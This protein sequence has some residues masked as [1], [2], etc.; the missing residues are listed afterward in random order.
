MIGGKLALT[1]RKIAQEVH[2]QE[3]HDDAMRSMLWLQSEPA[4]TQGPGGPL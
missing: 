3:L 1:R 2:D 4:R